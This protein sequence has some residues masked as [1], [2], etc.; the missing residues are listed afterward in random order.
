MSSPADELPETEDGAVQMF[1]FVEGASFQ[2]AAV[3]AFSA[4]EDVGPVRG[5]ETHISNVRF[6]RFCFHIG[7]HVSLSLSTERD[8]F[9][10]PEKSTEVKR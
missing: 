10:N 2:V 8:N 5:K 1:L 6:S 9:P 7:H 3:G 4:F